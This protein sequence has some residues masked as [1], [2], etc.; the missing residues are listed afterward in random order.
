MIMLRMT[1]NR[2]T[3]DK[4][5]HSQRSTE[6]NPFGLTHIK[7]NSNTHK[8]SVYIEMIII[9]IILASACNLAKQTGN[10]LLMGRF[11]SDKTFRVSLSKSNTSND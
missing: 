3:S 2:I 5:I 10:D 7:F 1:I 11:E 4:Q 9:K 8:S 6:W